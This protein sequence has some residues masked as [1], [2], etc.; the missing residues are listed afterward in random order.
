[1]ETRLFLALQC[2][3]VRHHAGVQ[4]CVAI[5]ISAQNSIPIDMVLLLDFALVSGEAAEEEQQHVGL[6]GVQ[7]VLVC[8]P[9]S[10]RALR[11]PVDSGSNGQ[12]KQF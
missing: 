11:D 3:A 2:C 6:H 4:P 8:A 1:M 9:C 12:R 5:A 7:P 10:H